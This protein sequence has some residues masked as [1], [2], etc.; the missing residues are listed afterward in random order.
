MNVEKAPANNNEEATLRETK[1][2]T[3]KLNLLIPL[4]AHGS[5]SQ[6]GMSPLP[7]LGLYDYPSILIKIFLLLAEAILSGFPFLI[8]KRTLTNIVGFLFC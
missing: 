2:L 6:R 5:R 8:T 4:S 1:Q 3:D 7:T